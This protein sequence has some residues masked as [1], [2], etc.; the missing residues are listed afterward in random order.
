MKSIMLKDKR[1]LSGWDMLTVSKE[2]WI[3][4]GK[5]KKVQRLICVNTICQCDFDCDLKPS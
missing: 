1:Y 3:L 5:G 2:L 4:V